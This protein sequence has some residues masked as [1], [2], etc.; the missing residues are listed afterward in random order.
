MK[1]SV[2]LIIIT[3]SLI[4]IIINNFGWWHN[5]TNTSLDTVIPYYKCDYNKNNYFTVLS[6]GDENVMN[7]FWGINKE[8]IKFLPEANFN[9]IDISKII[10]NST[11]HLN[12][13][14]PNIELNLIE[15]KF[16]RIN[17]KDLLDNKNWIVLLTYQYNKL[18]YTQMIPMLIDGRIVLSNNE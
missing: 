2:I 4:L 12:K 13:R 16:E 5:L 8:Y 3:F 18:G 11:A 10:K 17:D 1:K 7:E 15:L 6:S 14:Y 9:Q